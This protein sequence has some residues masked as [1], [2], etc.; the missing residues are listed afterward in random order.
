MEN[1]LRRVQIAMVAIALAGVLACGRGEEDA[2]PPPQ[3]P[4]SSGWRPSGTWT[5][6][7]SRRRTPPGAWCPGTPSAPIRPQPGDTP[8][9]RRAELVDMAGEVMRSWTG[10]EVERWVRAVLARN[11]DLLVIVA[12]GG[13]NRSHVLLRLTW[14]GALRWRR[15]LPV[16]HDVVERRE[17]SLAVLTRRQR[18]LPRLWSQSYLVDNA[19]AVLSPDGELLEERSLYDM[20]A[21]RPDLFAFLPIESG[22][23]GPSWT[24]C[25]RT[26]STGC[27]GRRWRAAT[28]STRH[29]TCWSRSATR[30]PS[31]S[32]TSRRVSW[33]GLGVR[34]SSFAPTTRPCS[35]AG[36]SWSSTTGRERS[37]LASSNSI[38][39]P[40][41]SSGSSPAARPDSTRAAGTVQR[42]P[43]G[44][45][46]IGESNRGRAFEV[47]P[48]GEV[49]WDYRTPHRNEKSQP[50][51]LRI[52]RYPPL[53]I[54]GSA[55]P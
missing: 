21:S 45:T 16:H 31:P 27:G 53:E 14:D 28:P 38:P 17:G 48:E 11:R 7:R 10:G 49:V 34:A 1:P 30:T 18:W 3:R 39:S 41:R 9:L 37:P 26:S 25:T 2:P 33:S 50:A 22:P 24:F 46:L 12:E 35:P 42:L 40:A 23:D 8:G 36:T 51:A 5:G 6:P 44:N 29:P 47:T 52:E 4:S 13:E 54:L 32:S 20:L 43:N 55:R 19:V 15:E